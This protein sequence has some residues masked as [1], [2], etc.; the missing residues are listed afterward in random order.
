MTEP[1]VLLHGFAGTRR[2]WQPVAERLGTQR[3]RPLAL[4]LR[5]HGDAAHARPVTP[6]ACTADVLAASGGRFALCGYS[7]GGRLALHVALAAPERVTRLILLATTAGIA[8]PSERAAR[9]RADEAL[10]AEIERSTI[11]AFADRWIAQPLFA[12]TPPAVVRAW[13][14][15]L[16]RNVPAGLA[17]ALRGLGPGAM[18][19]LWDRLPELD[20]P[21]TVVA[22]A[23]DPAYL[24]L[25]ER[26]ASALPRAELVVV[27]AAGHGLAREAPG[28]V[29]GLLAA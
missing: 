2:S 5:G 21:A 19:P 9:R 18:A 17:A 25:A 6:A 20:V 10:A 26:L 28:A 16:A 14:A 7:L 27:P 8:G 12:G 4:D 13:R 15:D 11:E 1:L 23:R 29:A 22:G 3:Y 24:V